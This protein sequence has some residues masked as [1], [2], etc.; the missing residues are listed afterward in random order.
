MPR[1]SWKAEIAARQAQ[2]AREQASLVPLD[3][4]PPQ[5]A[6]DKDLAEPCVHCGV[7]GKHYP[8]DCPDWEKGVI[9]RRKEECQLCR[10][11]DTIHMHHALRIQAGKAIDFQ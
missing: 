7:P 3:Q 2:R 11:T 9:A 5:L 6:Q 1:K 10:E 8:W 4:Y